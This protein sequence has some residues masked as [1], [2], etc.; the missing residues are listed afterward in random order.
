MNHKKLIFNI[1]I[2]LFL[3]LRGM[4]PLPITQYIERSCN[5][6]V[7]SASIIEFWNYTT[8]SRIH[9]SPALGDIDGDGNLEVIFGSWD[10]KI[11]ALNAEDG[12][13]LWN[14]TTNGR[15]YSSPA[16]GDLDFDDKL[17]IVFGSEDY[18]VYALN[19]ED[20]SKLWNYSTGDAVISSPSLGDID[21]DG[22]ELWNFITGARVFSSPALGDIDNDARLSGG[23]VFRKSF[24]SFAYNDYR[25]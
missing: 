19:G 22:S 14:F 17:E 18:N 10:N 12:S 25:N 7:S 24:H 4:S 21:K 1:I 20:G 8:G 16:L 9:S 23:S 5:T 2:L 13:E 6:P 11:Y 15:I 3:M